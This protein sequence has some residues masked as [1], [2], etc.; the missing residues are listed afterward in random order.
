[1]IDDKET[2]F[3]KT[4]STMK[5]KGSKEESLLTIKESVFGIT[6]EFFWITVMIAFLGLVSLVIFYIFR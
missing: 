6:F 4:F 5:P 3:F 1:M 2:G